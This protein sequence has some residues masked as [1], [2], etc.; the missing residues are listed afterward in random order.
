V[1]IFEAL[2]GHT[3]YDADGEA[4][5]REELTPEEIREI[6]ALYA[7]GAYRQVDLAEEY[8]VSQPYISR[9]VNRKRRKGVE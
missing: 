4:V 5:L 8:G 3:E 2:G 9:I 7:G 1:S 6:R